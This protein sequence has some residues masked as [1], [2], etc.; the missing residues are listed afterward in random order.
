MLNFFLRIACNFGMADIRLNSR[1]SFLLPSTFSAHGIIQETLHRYLFVLCILRGVL[2]FFFPTVA[3]VSFQKR[4][5]NLSQNVDCLV[6]EQKKVFNDGLK[7][8]VFKEAMILLALS[9]P[10]TTFTE[11]SKNFDSYLYQKDEKLGNS[12]TFCKSFSCYG[13]LNLSF[14]S[15]DSNLFGC[16]G[17][18]EFQSEFVRD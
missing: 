11:N 12:S 10:S 13:H 6:A 18:E 7:G 5:M 14:L 9:F 15:K 17:L 4:E 1:Y 2:F 16:T 8:K 3:S